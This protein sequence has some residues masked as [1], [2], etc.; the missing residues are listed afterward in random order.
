METEQKKRV[1]AGVGIMLYRDGKI[2]LGLRHSDPAKAKSSLRGEGTLT[3]P[4]GKLEFGETME[5]G[6]KREVL[7]ETGIILNDARVMCINTDKNEHAHYITVGVYCD[8]FTGEAELKEPEEIVRWD[9][10]DVKNLPEPMF[11]SCVHI[12]ENYRQ[13]K[14]Y[15]PDMI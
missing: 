6:A 7:E 9:W 14:F 4:G 2:L 15:I 3:M 11:R 13:G 8:N 1:G 12:M 5:E 10:F